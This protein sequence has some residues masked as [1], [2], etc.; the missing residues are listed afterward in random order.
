MNLKRF[1]IIYLITLTSLIFPGIGVNK[2]LDGLDKPVFVVSKNTNPEYLY[3]VEQDGIIKLA[4]DGKINKKLF[5]DITSSVH[6]TL[7]PGDEQGLLGLA[8]HP[9]FEKNGYLF[10]NYVDRNGFTIISRFESN[11]DSANP[12]SEKI[13]FKIEQPYSN[14]NGGHLAFGPDGYLYIGLGDGGS[15]G[16]PENRAQDLKS[17]FGKM[18]RIDINNANSDPYVIPQDNPFFNKKNII[19][20]IWA[21]GLRNPWRYSFDKLTGDLYIGDVGQNNWEEID[22]QLSSSLG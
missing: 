10:V 11:I 22:F 8:L 16:D 6:Q 20:E 1:S 2:I 12:L 5:L 13:I 15:S 18:L 19:K 21:Y 17:Y 3:I 9:E 7:Y 14:H 4:I